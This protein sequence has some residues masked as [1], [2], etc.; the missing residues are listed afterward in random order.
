MPQRANR[1]DSLNGKRIGLLSTG[2]TNCDVLLT[3]IGALLKQ[4]FEAT[5]YHLWTKPSVY[6]FSRLPFL[7]DMAAN[8]DAVVVGLGDCGHGSSCTFHDVFWF[9]EQGIPVA[10][11]DTPGRTHNVRRDGDAFVVEYRTLKY[12]VRDYQ[13]FDAGTRPAYLRKHLERQGIYRALRIAGAR[14]GNRIRMLDEEIVLRDLPPP[15]KDWLPQ[16]EGIPNY[17]YIVTDAIGRLDEPQLVAR[18]RE[19]LP[20]VLDKLEGS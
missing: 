9:E 12:V 18:A 17:P 16:S 15:P 4:R 13:R 6:R 8:S 20:L 2:K 19:L 3:N 5:S 14:P 1:L 7:Q 10:C 11:V